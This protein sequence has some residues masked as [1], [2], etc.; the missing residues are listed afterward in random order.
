MKSLLKMYLTKI[1]ITLFLHKNFPCFVSSQNNNLID[2][3]SSIL[4]SMKML[5]NPRI[6]MVG[7]GRMEF[8]SFKFLVRKSVTYS[9]NIKINSP[10][11]NNLQES[12]FYL[13]LPKV[14]EENCEINIFM[15]TLELQQKV[16]FKMI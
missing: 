8:G 6:T 2:L 5:N 1:T 14:D 7:K 11:E 10:K 13:V 15:H 3:N 9:T 4:K 16:I 12:N